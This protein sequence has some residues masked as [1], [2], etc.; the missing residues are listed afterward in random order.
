MGVGLVRSLQPPD[1]LW[2][3]WRVYNSIANTSK[4]GSL[5]PPS[6][7]CMRSF[8]Y[9]LYTL[10]KL[11]Y[12]KALSD[13]ASSLAPDWIHLL[14]RPRIPCLIVQQQPFN[15][16]EIQ[17]VHP[18]GNQS[19]IFIGRTDAE[20]ETPILWLPDE[21]YWLIWKDPDA[22][23]DWRREE[24][25]STEDEMVE[26]SINNSMDMSLS[27]L[28]VG[29]GQGSLECCCP[30]GCKESDTTEWLNWN[31]LKFCLWAIPREPSTFQG[32]AK[33]WVT[34]LLP[35]ILCLSLPGSHG[36]S[37]ACFSG[38]TSHCRTGLLNLLAIFVLYL[39]GEITGKKGSPFC[40]PA[41]LRTPILW[42]VG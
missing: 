14:R 38:I 39:Q 2:I 9:L 32:T 31:E 10:I 13:P 33:Q 8:L 18:S 6:D 5:L 12:T 15:C 17:P 35:G 3:P 30:W 25:G 21:K 4:L 24:K 36:A 34:R 16:K 41:T 7:V 23:K 37:A 29:D 42:H 28:G 11:Y 22:G 40:Q 1:S 20:A 26:L 27:K 19:W